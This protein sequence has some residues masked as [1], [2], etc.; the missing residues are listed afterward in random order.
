MQTL[1]AGM[2]LSLVSIY[3]NYNSILY[4]FVTLTVKGGHVPLC[5]SRPVATDYFIVQHR[6]M[7]IFTP[8]VKILSIHKDIQVK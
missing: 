2:R 5:P 7:W 3:T 4:F 1:G 6:S 8:D